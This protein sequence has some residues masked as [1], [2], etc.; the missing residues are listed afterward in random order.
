VQQFNV[1]AEQYKSHKVQNAKQFTEYFQ[2][3]HNHAEVSDVR[4]RMLYH[5]EWTKDQSTHM[6]SSLVS[7]QFVDSVVRYKE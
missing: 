7:L 2:R 3:F 5:Q 1:E 6:S 4:E